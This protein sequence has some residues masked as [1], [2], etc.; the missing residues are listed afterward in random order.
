MQLS[1]ATTLDYAVTEPVDILLQIEAA[2]IPEQR[3]LDQ[4]SMS[5]LAA[6]R[7]IRGSM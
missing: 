4:I 1:I 6:Q 5:K 3:I 7:L 2:V